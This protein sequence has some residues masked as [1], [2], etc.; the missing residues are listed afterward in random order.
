MSDDE[1][2][3]REIDALIAGAMVLSVAAG[4]TYEGPLLEIL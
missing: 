1:T 2:P 4:G 3:R